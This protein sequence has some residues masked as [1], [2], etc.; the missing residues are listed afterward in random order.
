MRKQLESASASA[1]RD[2]SQVRQ[3]DRTHGA[4][5]PGTGRASRT[6]T[7]GRRGTGASGQYVIL[8]LVRD[9]LHHVA[10]P[11]RIGERVGDRISREGRGRRPLVLTLHAAVAREERQVVGDVDRDRDRRDLELAVVRLGSRERKWLRRFDRG[12]PG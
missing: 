1:R 7:T 3:H 11:A 9:L 2:I 8:R 12:D 6:L 4:L 5:A 10:L